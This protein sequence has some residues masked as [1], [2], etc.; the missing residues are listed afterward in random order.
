MAEVLAAAKAVFTLIHYA[1][2]TITY[3]QDAKGADDE[4][5]KLRNEITV[6]IQVLSK[7]QIKS[8]EDEWKDTMELLNASQGPFDQFRIVLE[9][10]KS[11]LKPAEGKMGKFGTAIIWPFKKPKIEKVLTTIEHSKSLFTLALQNEH[12]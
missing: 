2:K 6:T 1:Q 10:L 9:E 3:I 8:N 12:M 11:K 4:R 7:L 5:T